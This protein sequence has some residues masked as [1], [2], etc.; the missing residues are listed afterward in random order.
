[1]SK[2]DPSSHR[3]PEQM[4]A[5]Y[6]DYQGK[7]EQIAKRS[8]RNKARRL[9]EKAGKVSRGDGLDVDHKR[10]LRAGGS[11]TAMSNLRAMPKSSNRGW[12][13]GV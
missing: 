10:P 1:M 12:R 7:P 8:G 4:K 2:R 9:M 13:S 6:R 5:H 3:T 11:A